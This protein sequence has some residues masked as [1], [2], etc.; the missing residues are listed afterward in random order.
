M[1]KHELAF[2]KI[3]KMKGIIPIRFLDTADTQELSSRQP[4]DY[5][6][7]GTDGISFAEVKG[8]DNETR[9]DFRRVRDAQWI[10]A[11]LITK[12]KQKYYFWV[13]NIREDKWYVIAAQYFLN[14]K[15]E[16]AKSVKFAD[17]IEFRR[18]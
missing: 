17:L 13:F 3:Q 15:R 4:S 18:P 14:L 1:N 8:C 10:Y 11:D 9:F 12:K 2:E 5:I 16:G 6:L 7:V